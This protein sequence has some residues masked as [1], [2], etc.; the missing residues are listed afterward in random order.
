[1]IGIYKITK[2]E[3][4]KCYIG[5]SVDCDRRIKE[6]CYPSRYKSGLAIDIAIHKYGTEAFT[7][8]I[9]EECPIEKLNERECYWIKYFNSKENGYNLSDGRD[10]QSIG[11]NNGRAHLTEEDIIFIRKAY[12]EHKKQKEIY[13]LF[14]DKITFSSFQAIW[15]GK[16]W[17]H[18]MPEVYTEENKKYYIYQNSLGENGSN[19]I[20]TDEEVLQVR[21]RYVNETAKQIFE[22]YKDR[23]Q[24]QTLQQIL[25]GRTYSYLPI[26][27][28]KEK[29]WI[30]I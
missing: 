13:K 3:N 14:K 15:Q 8:E 6:H 20:L 10:Q 30:N 26:Y 23:L 25:W 18:I 2:K 19:A 7:Y 9:V 11:E 5:Q 1:M 28:K 22:D 29:I 12:N 27:K 17:V 24:Y 16:T 21:K 4:G